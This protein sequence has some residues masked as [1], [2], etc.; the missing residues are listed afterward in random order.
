MPG[1]YSLCTNFPMLYF[2][3]LMNTNSYNIVEKDKILKNAFGELKDLGI[4]SKWSIT[5]QPFTCLQNECKLLASDPAISR[6]IET[7]FQENLIIERAVEMFF[8]QISMSARA[9]WRDVP[10]EI[11]P[12]TARGWFIGRW[13]PTFLIVD[14]P[15]GR[16]ICKGG[17]PLFDCLKSQYL[18]YPFLS[19][20]RDFLN[21]DLFRKLRNGFG[22][23]AFDWEVIDLESYVVAYDWRSGLPTAR[24]HQKQADAFHIIAFALIEVLD[25]TI[26]SEFKKKPRK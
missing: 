12:I 20:A 16:F 8:T 21:N 6:E 17:S 18:K 4:N 15:I 10:D 13:I 2:Y 1:F 19:S 22:H 24:L 23:W 11:R 9:N 3:H 25:E 26:I 7:Y 5:S 14:G